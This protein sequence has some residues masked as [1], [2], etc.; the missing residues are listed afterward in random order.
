MVEDWDQD[1]YGHYQM[2]IEEDE[3]NLQ[4]TTESIDEEDRLHAEPQFEDERGDNEELVTDCTLD[5]TDTF[6]TQEE[7]MPSSS[8]VSNPSENSALKPLVLLSPSLERGREPTVH[9]RDG[10]IQHSVSTSMETQSY[11]TIQPEPSFAVSNPQRSIEEAMRDSGQPSLETAA[12]SSVIILDNPPA[13]SYV[14]EESPTADFQGLFTEPSLIAH[15][16]SVTVDNKLGATDSSVWD[17][18]F[19][20]HKVSVVESKP[21]TNPV[22][23]LNKA[24]ADQK[25]SY[26]NSKSSAL[27]F[28][29][30]SPVA[31]HNEPGSNEDESFQSTTANSAVV[32]DDRPG[33]DQKAIGCKPSKVWKRSLECESEFRQEIVDCKFA[34]DDKDINEEISHK[35][36]PK[37]KESL[38]IGSCRKASKD[39]KPSNKKL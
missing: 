8:F 10:P 25:K 15:D 26:L 23:V 11:P 6:S 4:N 24:D 33:K 16:K 39:E 14:V 13:H 3:Y 22:V 31:D 37:F 28:G 20:E 30:C 18:T 34:V 7:D 35:R 38:S 2:D 21:V 32:I 5:N 12:D 29:D 36:E 27:F 9:S 19:A 1:Q 17:S